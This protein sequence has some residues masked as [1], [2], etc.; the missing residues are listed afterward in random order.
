MKELCAFVTVYMIGTWFGIWWQN[1]E[2]KRE[3]H[4]NARDKG[5][6][7]VDDKFYRVMSEKEAVDLEIAG[8]KKDV[9]D[10][11]N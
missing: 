2:W 6:F 7:K 11:A 9:K 3:L 4:R 8:L 10:E 5:A 1:K